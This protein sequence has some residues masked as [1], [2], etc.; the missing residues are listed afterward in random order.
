MNFVDKGVYKDDNMPSIDDYKGLVMGI[1][2]S[3]SI[4]V[5]PTFNVIDSI[6][7][8]VIGWFS[9]PIE[10]TEIRV[11]SSVDGGNTWDEMINGQY[12][13][14]VKVLNDS[15]SIKLK[16]VVKSYISQILPENSPKLFEVILILSDE[17]QNY[18]STKAILNINWDNKSKQ[19]LSW[20]TDTQ[21]LSWE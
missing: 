13:Q 7:S 9:R 5:S 6:N 18:W 17:E 2:I 8:G 10:G 11:L 16:Y 12:L 20:S 4:D 21:Q 1:R 15:P 14:N 3:P 19:N